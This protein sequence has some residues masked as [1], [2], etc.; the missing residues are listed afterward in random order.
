[1]IEEVKSRRYKVIS[2]DTLKVEMGLARSSVS[3]SG[4]EELRKS[5]AARGVLVPILVAEEK[6]GYRVIAGARRAVAAKEAGLAMV[7]AIVVDAERSWEWWAK[8]AENEL[9]EALN[10]YDLATWLKA[11]LDE[12]GQSQAEL[13]S[14]LG[15]SEPWVSQRLALLSWPPDVRDAVRVGKLSYA[16]GRELAAVSEDSAREGYLRSAV[17]SGCTVRQAAQWR[18]GWEASKAGKQP[19]VVA[20]LPSVE[21]SGEPGAVRECA[22]CRE[23]KPEGELLMLVLCKTCAETLQELSQRI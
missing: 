21:P 23:R 9:R 17:V 8:L 1:M 4:M 10:A 13:A 19:S 16:V 6:E 18:R 20:E 14:A 11:L 3:E 12:S 15:V 2:L 22:V 5:V 7:P